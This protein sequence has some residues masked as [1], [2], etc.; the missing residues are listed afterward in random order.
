[1]KTA[2]PIRISEADPFKVHEELAKRYNRYSR[3]DEMM[4]KYFTKIREQDITGAIEVTVAFREDMLQ[5]NQ[6]QFFPVINAMNQRVTDWAL[7]IAKS[8]GRAS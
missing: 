2:M 4:E 8:G 7:A 3:F 1:M 6:S 5:T